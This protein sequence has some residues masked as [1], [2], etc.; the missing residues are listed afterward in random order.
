MELVAQLTRI[1]ADDV[2]NLL[3]FKEAIRDSEQGMHAGRDAILH[4]EVNMVRPACNN[5]KRM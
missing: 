3:S 5:F 1:L 2:P 4:W